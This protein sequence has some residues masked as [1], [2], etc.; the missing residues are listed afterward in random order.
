MEV[1]VHLGAHAEGL[2]VDPGLHGEGQ[3]RHQG[4]E[5][6]GFQVVQVG[7]G[8]V[9]LL[10]QVVPGAVADVGA[11]AL[12]LQDLARQA[13]H[14]KALGVAAFPVGPFHEGDGLVPRPGHR[15]E[16][17]VGRLR[18]PF[19]RHP[20]EVGVDPPGALAHRSRRTTAPS[21]RRT[22]EGSWWGLAA[23]FPKA[24]MGGGQR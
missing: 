17:P 23:F 10:P 9:D 12:L 21:S 19:P 18:G 11:I 1:D 4:A 13:V 5:V 3:A 2:Q 22:S 6:V 14:L 24:T 16:G 20:G 15:L 8:A 7:P